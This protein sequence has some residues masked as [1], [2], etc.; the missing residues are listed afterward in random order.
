M[1]T[2][3]Y[4][5]LELVRAPYAVQPRK[6]VQRL[7]P[8]DE[9]DNRTPTQRDRDRVIH[10]GSFRKLKGKTQVF[11]DGQGDYFRTRLTHSMEVAQISRSMARILKLDEDLA[12]CCALAH[13]IG[14]PPF[15]HTGEDALD[16]CMK[17]VGGFDHNEQALRAL[18]VIERPYNDQPGLNLCWDT[19]EGILKHNGP[20]A[21]NERG[22]T[23]RD[24]DKKMDLRLDGHASLEAQLA[25]ISDDIAYNA[26]D[27]DDAFRA[28]LLTFEQI[29]SM[30][31][32]KDVLD[33]GEAKLWSE[34]ER[35]RVS[36]AVR[37]VIGLWV[38]DAVA[39]TKANLAKIKPSSADDIRNAGFTVG[40]FAPATWDEIKKLKKFMLDNV[41]RHPRLKE[42][43]VGATRTV[44]ELFAALMKDTDQLSPEYRMR[45]EGIERAIGD[46]IGG[47][48]DHYVIAT[49]KRLTGTTVLN[50]AA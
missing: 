8:I 49:H 35:G 20:I 5:N 48:T 2:V 24:F 21:A 4:G 27:V 11:I 32:Y 23:I 16:E 36:Y 9:G 19:L 12:E 50:Y 25:A 28:G 22:P 29:R 33:G 17:A 10:S 38:A 44:T 34:D 14:H 6:D 3:K 7:Q 45:D 40:D 15:G 41:Y 47:M 43:R 1:T 39:N 37:H 26:H 42:M 30:P 18:M 46:Y 13:D 31:F